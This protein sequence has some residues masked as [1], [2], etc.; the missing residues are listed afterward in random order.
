MIFN[1]MTPFIAWESAALPV[2]ARMAK[3]FSSGGKC[4]NQR[5]QLDTF[6]T[7]VSHLS[8]SWALGAPT[9]VDALATFADFWRLNGVHTFVVLMQ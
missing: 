4:P 7:Q 9:K 3:C 6:P 2:V 8:S 5:F 1:A